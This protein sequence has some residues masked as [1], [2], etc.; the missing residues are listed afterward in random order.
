MHARRG[1]WLV[2]RG[3]RVE[4]ETTARGET[5]LARFERPRQPDGGARGVPA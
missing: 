1:D 3:A 2:V 4:A 5:D